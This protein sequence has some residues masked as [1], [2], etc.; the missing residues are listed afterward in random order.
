MGVRNAN[1]WQYGNK[2][3]IWREKK[4]RGVE[5]EEDDGGDDDDDDDEEDYDDDDEEEEEEEERNRPTQYFSKFF[6]I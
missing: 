1:A 2:L 5:E 6:V 3:R 4:I